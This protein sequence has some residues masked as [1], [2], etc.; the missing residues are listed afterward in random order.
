MPGLIL[1]ID[2][3]HQRVI[4]SACGHVSIH[5]QIINKIECYVPEKQDVCIMNLPEGSETTRA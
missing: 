3:E 2:E 1:V 4:D 5:E